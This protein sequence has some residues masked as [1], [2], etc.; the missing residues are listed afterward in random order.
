MKRSILYNTHQIGLEGLSP[1]KP[2]RQKEKRNMIMGLMLTSLVDAFSI[3]VIYLIMSTSSGIEPENLAKD[4]QLPKASSSQMAETGLLV[5]VTPRG[6]MIN[7]QRVEIENLAAYLG[8]QHEQLKS[9]DEERSKKLI[10]QA[11]KGASFEDLNPVVL[12]G[13]QSGFETIIFAVVQQEEKK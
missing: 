13:T 3:I 4:I 10:L 2:K 1:L 8:Q 9:S 11:D 7:D 5:M 6:I 12:A